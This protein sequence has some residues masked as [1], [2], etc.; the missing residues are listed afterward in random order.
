M[1]QREVEQKIRAAGI[2]ASNEK[3]FHSNT[4]QAGCVGLDYRVPSQR[5]QAEK[6]MA[7]HYEQAQK[8]S[9]AAN[10]F[11]ENPAFDEFIRLI[12]AGVIQI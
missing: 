6:N 12:R 4:Q 5:E 3:A 8:S 1:N 2:P 9:E 7:H 11:R 10:F